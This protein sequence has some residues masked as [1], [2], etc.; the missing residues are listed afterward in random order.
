MSKE[1]KR[2]T[3]IDE[4][5]QSEFESRG[6]AI[7]VAKYYLPFV[8]L[9]GITFGL[10]LYVSGNIYT[11]WKSILT[12]IM[13]VEFFGGLLLTYISGRKYWNK[14]QSMPQPIKLDK[15]PS[16]FWMFNRNK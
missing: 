5:G 16:Y 7:T 11:V 6:I 9:F 13:G 8:V 15:I 3:I 1:I 12:A 4:W 14:M 2:L 10:F